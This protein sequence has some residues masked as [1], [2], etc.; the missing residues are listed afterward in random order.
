MKINYTFFFSFL[1]LCSAIATAR[2]THNSDIFDTAI[3]QMDTHSKELN[4]QIYSSQQEGFASQ[5][6]QRLELELSTIKAEHAQEIDDIREYYEDKIKKLEDTLAQAQEKQACVSNALA[7]N[8]E[9]LENANLS[10]NPPE[11]LPAE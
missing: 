7:A 9:N 8:Q 11:R 5:K 3:K 2:S 6:I 10:E 1:I 4:Q